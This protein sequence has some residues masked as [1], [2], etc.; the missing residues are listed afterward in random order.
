MLSLISSLCLI[1]LGVM[2]KYSDGNTGWSGTK[3]YANYFIIGGVIA[4]II[5]VI[6]LF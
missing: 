5:G 2:A 4:L 3:K 1:F 6:K